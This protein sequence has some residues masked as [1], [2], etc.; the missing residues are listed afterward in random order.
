M[1][2]KRGASLGIPIL[3]IAVGVGWLLTAVGYAPAI[4]WTW[5][6]GLA[7]VGI[8]T[9]ALSGLD[10]AS[11]VIGPF[12]LLASVLSVLRQ[13]GALEVNVEVPVLVTAVGVLLAL[14]RLP[15]IPLPGWLE[16]LPPSPTE[17]H[18]NPPK[19]LRL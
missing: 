11:V 7:A 16:P 9:L 8:L 1:H 2:P 15:W 19:K 14:A 6:I 3:V 17:E 18:A 10:K 5:T 12:F 13:T 4:N